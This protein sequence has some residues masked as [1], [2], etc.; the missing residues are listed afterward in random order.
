MAR[1]ALPEPFDLFLASLPTCAGIYVLGFCQTRNIPTQG[2]KLIQRQRFD[3]AT[4]RLEH[5]E[6]EIV[7]P[8]G[9]PEKYRTAVARAAEGCKVKKVLAS[10]PEVA[11]VINAQAA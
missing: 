5:V 2:I 10:P 8:Q 4:H 6:L 3:E 9:F 1:A 7:L 11:V